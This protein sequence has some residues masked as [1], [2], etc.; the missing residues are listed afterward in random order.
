MTAH[1]YFDDAFEI[2]DVCDDWMQVNQ[3][4]RLFVACIDE[5]G[6]YVHQTN[7][8]LRPPKKVPT[9]Y[10]GRLVYSLPGKTKMIVHLKDK[11][12]IRHK[13]RWS[14]CMYMY[15]LLGHRLMELPIAVDRKDVLAENTYILT[16]DGDIDFQPPAVSLLVDLMKKNKNLGAACG[17][18]H[19]V[20]SGPMV[21]YQLF[22]Y[23]IG[24]WL[25]KATEHMI[26]CVMCSPGCFS[27]F[28]AKA[29]MDDNVMR[30][31]TTKSEEPR[32]YV[33]YDQGEDRWL[34]TLL[35]QRGYRVEYSAA[36][37]AYTHCPEG[38]NEFFNQRRR[39]VPST[40]A[41]I[42]DLLV[43]YKR[44]VKIN[45][46]I[47]LPY[48]WYQCMLM[49]G[50]IIGPGTIFLMLVG[51]FVAAFKISNWLSFYYNLWPIVLYTLCCL[52]CKSNWQL[53]LSG[54][55]STFYA[56][57]MMAVIVGTALQLGED[58]IGS[59]SA[60]FLIS[61][62]G[63]F[64]IAA[65]LHPQEFWCVVPGLIYLLCIPSM[66]L[67]LIIYSIT[68]LNV[69]SWGTREVAVKKTKKELEEERK[70]AQTIQ[71]KAKKE[72]VWGL[73]L[74]GSDNDEEEGGIDFSIGNVIRLML[75]THKK[76]TH[77]RD[78]LLRIADSLDT[79][80]K[81]LDHIE[82]YT[83]FTYRYGFILTFIFY[84][85]VIDP[86]TKKQRRKSSRMSVHGE[87]LTNVSEGGETMDMDSNDEES[88]IT[89]PREERDDLIN[90]FW[91]EDK[92][93]GRGEVD[94][95]SGVEIQ[96]WKDLIEKYLHPL[97]AD[98]QKQVRNH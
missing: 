46:N 4:V 22:E 35:L 87:I 55:L 96:F 85:S 59:P 6:S 34:C 73:L 97:D 43:D 51:A 52:T 11:S 28:R 81:R 44:T 75:F 45:D 70:Q 93:I 24:H 86:H 2:S 5:A 13:K 82:K 16:L 53:L 50:T 3:F 47:S 32:H 91:I 60:I 80:T 79:L 12:K 62:V 25:Q 67:L 41:N 14:Q 65:V 40:I 30:R 21:W 78:Q 94:Y 68:N 92:D 90:P 19:P 37:D 89:E 15:Y 27:L 58:G 9:P 36:S 42:F 49:S 71:K 72:G 7:I 66:Y 88:E 69:V 20:G 64:F 63:S 1:I 8:R 31:Y 57:I 77:E 56:L 17:R 74:N 95:L 18:I 54:I 10:G 26:G 39:W 23:A 76:E 84:Y 83:N 48:I 98:K 38:F 61:M 29:L 33:Q